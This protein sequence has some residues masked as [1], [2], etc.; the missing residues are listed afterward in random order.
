[1]ILGLQSQIIKLD[2]E[3]EEYQQKIEEITEKKRKIEATLQLF[4][5]ERAEKSSIPIDLEQP[6]EKST[7]ISKTKS[8]ERIDNKPRKPSFGKQTQSIIPVFTGKS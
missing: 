4:L 7:A 3:I 1:M 6:S 8:S 5:A 2:K